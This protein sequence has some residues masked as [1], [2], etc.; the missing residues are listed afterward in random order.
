M[1]ATVEQLM[2]TTQLSPRKGW[3]FLQRLAMFILFLL[4]PLAQSGCGYVAAGAAG[5]VVG[6]EVAEDEAEDEEEE[7]EEERK[8]N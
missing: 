1:T 6:H 2:K 4:G 5:A 7:E 8:R 3:L